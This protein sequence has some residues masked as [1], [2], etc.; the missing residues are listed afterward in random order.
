M[1]LISDCS[2]VESVQL[3]ENFVA[4]FQPLLIRLKEVL[5]KASRDQV[6]S[7]ILLSEASICNLASSQIWALFHEALWMLSIC[8]IFIPLA[9][10]LLLARNPW[11]SCTVPWMM[12]KNSG[13]FHSNGQI[14]TGSY[15]FQMVIHKHRK[16]QPV[17]CVS[18]IWRIRIWSINAWNMKTDGINGPSK[19]TPCSWFC[20]C[21]CEN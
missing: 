8:R 21:I 1:P 5:G 15:V 9:E 4:A 13:V 2:V 18:L 16:W 19:R 17:C 20:V 14:E 7:V 10:Y 12:A 11:K 6:S 3:Q